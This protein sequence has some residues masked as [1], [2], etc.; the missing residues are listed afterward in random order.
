MIEVQS[1][2]GIYRAKTSDRSRRRLGLHIARQR[3]TESKPQVSV[4]RQFPDR[5]FETT[6]LTHREPT[7][8][9]TQYF[10]G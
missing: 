6:S 10:L 2:D 3:Q 9:T 5:G 1:W 8:D 4:S 7:V